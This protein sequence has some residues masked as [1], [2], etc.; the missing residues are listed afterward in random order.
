MYR[1]SMYR[2]ATQTTAVKILWRLV[3]EFCLPSTRQPGDSHRQ[4][5]QGIERWELKC[6]AC[7]QRPVDLVI[8][9]VVQRCID[10]SVVGIAL[11]VDVAKGVVICAIAV[12][13]LGR[14]HKETSFNQ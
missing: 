14:D 3:T 6:V 1:V 7:R 10:S 2:D 9:D 5:R 8:G 13:S 4:M 11:E 12:I